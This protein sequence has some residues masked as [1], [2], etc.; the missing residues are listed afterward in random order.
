MVRDA[1]GHLAEDTPENRAL[2]TETAN[3]P[4]NLLGQDQ[5]GNDW[6]ARTRTNGSQVWVRVRNGQITNG[7]VNSTPRTWD[8]QRGLVP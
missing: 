2:L 4:A 3:D 7:G 5:Y 8:Q 6:Y 1:A